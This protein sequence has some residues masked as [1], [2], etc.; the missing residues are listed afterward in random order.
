METNEYILIGGGEH[1]RVVL[2]VLLSNKTK[3]NALFDPKYS[4]K[5]FGINQLGN[6]KATLFSHSLAIV[7]IGD[8]ATRKKAC[9]SVV[10]PFGNAVHGS[11]QVS[12]FAKVL[13]G[14]V[15]FHHA[16]V[17]ANSIIGRH[18]II[19]TGAQVDH[20]CLIGD[21]VH[22]APGAILCGTVTV[23]EGALIGA[24]ATLIPGVEI[25]SWSTV[26]AGSV[27]TKSVPDNAMVG[28][29]P[30]RVIKISRA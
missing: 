5:L 23:G 13:E 11:A 4:G 2:D 9:A 19:N 8:N 15:L 17:Q 22:I 3:V 1:A 12:Q 21:Y 20:D 26:A 25:G 14:S 10:H 30:A 7:A 16:V 18:V 24:G 28:G 6:Y 29:I 27:V